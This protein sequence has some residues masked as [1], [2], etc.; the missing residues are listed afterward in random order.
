[1]RKSRRN[2]INDESDQEVHRTVGQPISEEEI[3][4]SEGMAAVKVNGKYGYIKKP[5]S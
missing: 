1:M 4:F 5:G 2:G 3:Y